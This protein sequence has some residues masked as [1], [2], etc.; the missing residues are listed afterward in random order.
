MPKQKVEKSPETP[1]EVETWEGEGGAVETPEQTPA[2]ALETVVEEEKAG[3]SWQEI[4]IQA[5][6][7]FPEDIKLMLSK[8]SKGGKLSIQQWN[9]LDNFSQLWF[10][11]TFGISKKKKRPSIQKPENNLVDRP[12]RLES[13]SREI[14][15]DSR[16]AKLAEEKR[17]KM[18]QL[19]RALKNL[20]EGESVEEFIDETRRVVSF[21]GAKQQYFV[22]E[23]GAEKV[24]GV[25][26]IVSDYAWGIKYLPD[27][28]MIDATAYRTLAKR[29]LINEA[30]RDLEKIHDKEFTKQGGFSF[31]KFRER[32][33]KTSKNNREVLMG[34]FG[35]IAEIIVREFLARISQNNNLD[36][37]VSRATIK[38]DRDFKYDF[39]IR[40]K[41]R[42]R[43]IDINSKLAYKF[44]GINLKTIV[45]RKKVS[46]GKAAEGIKEEVDEIFIL[47]VP[48]KDIRKAFRQWFEAGEPSRGPEQFLSPELK[49][50][51]L[52][53]VTEKLVEVPQDVFDKIE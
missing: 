21:D 37:V 29:I 26:D 8:L 17:N 27:S 46:I 52:K 23:N 9:R 3:I 28:R 42:I 1:P 38:E 32:F 41:Q 45:K 22:E 50:A 19:H 48:A 25:G 51:I 5:Q 34:E 40:V 53:A 31:S 2:K 20:D 16:R 14:K 13:L 30:R 10:R 7:E 6:G 44:L 15:T 24:I 35:F 47:K 49:K 4:L 12:K 36:F 11:E 43:G 39:K 33:L 18:E